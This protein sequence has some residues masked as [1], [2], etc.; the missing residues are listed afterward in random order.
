MHCCKKNVMTS[1]NVFLSLYYDIFTPNNNFGH[2]SYPEVKCF[3]CIG[4]KILESN[5]FW[6]CF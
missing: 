5:E 2:L 1:N 4:Y 3:L 6:M